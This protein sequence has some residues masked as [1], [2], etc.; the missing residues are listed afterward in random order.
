MIAALRHVRWPVLA[1][2]LAVAGAARAGS[3]AQPG[4]TVGLPTGAQLPVGLYFVDTSSLGERG[5]TPF[6]SSSNINLPTFV[7][8][9]PFDIVGGHLQLVFIQPVL[10][11]A[12]QRTP[13]RVGFGQQFYAGQLAFDLGH[14]LGI[15]YLFGV[16]LPTNTP[17][18]TRN[19]SFSH[20]VAMSYTGERYNLTAN[21]LYGNFIDD[22]SPTNTYYP[23]YLNLDLTAT[24]KFGKWQI[25][26]VAFGS[27][28]L[29][30]PADYRRQGQFAAGALLGYDFGPV[31]LQTY[32]TRDL[33]ERNYGGYDTRGWVRV[34]VPFFQNKAQA[35]PN[36]TLVTRAQSE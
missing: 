6:P 2:C 19:A 20:R 36:R 22:R 21:F 32:L 24:R 33:V 16:Y 9:T 18:A 35:E 13:Y 28:D 15:S 7:W 14:D 31:N 3:A 12:P 11:V 17:F 4:Q 29:T 26:A 23:D 8:S 10:N 34:I 1:L 30:G 25:G 5:T 27:T